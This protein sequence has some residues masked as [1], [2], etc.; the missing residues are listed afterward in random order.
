MGFLNKPSFLET[1][2]MDRMA[3]EGAHL[4]NA[5]VVTSLCSPSRASIL[6]GKFPQT[7]GVVDNQHPLP[8]HNVIFPQYLKDAGYKTAFIGKWHMGGHTDE[9]RPGFDHWVSFP[10]QGVYYDPEFNVN[11]ESIEHNGYI[12][13]LLTDYAVEWIGKQSNDQPFMLYLSHKAVHAMFEPAKRHLGLFD[14]IKPE[15]PA[16]M[17]NT[18]ENYRGKPEW[19]KE[20]RHSWHG[21]DY[22][23]HGEM[24]FDTFYRRY[25]E[26]LL[27]LDESIGRVLNALEKKELSKNTLVI[28]TSDNGF[29]LGEHGLIDKRHMYR[30]SIRIPL[31]ALGPGLIK[32]A[33]KITN[34]IQNVD[35]APTF[36]EAAGIEP[37]DDMDGKSFLPLLKGTDVSRREEV[38]YEYYWERPFPH[39]PTVFGVRTETYKYMT[40]HGIWD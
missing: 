38:Y 36:L 23:Y 18:K 34:L 28:Y 33:T 40:Y 9:P 31:L 15:Y 6:T 3:R 26:T 13:D 32:A 30:E 25:C 7:H 2:A 11:G 4:E 29:T 12:T 1:P 39:T 27:S 17:A 14:K 22:M 5:F 35:F 21:V 37:P 20:Q 8:E 19:V 10:G 16:S 24:E